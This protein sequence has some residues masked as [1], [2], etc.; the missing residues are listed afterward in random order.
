MHRLLCFF[1]FATDFDPLLVEPPDGSY[2]HT[3]AEC[4]RLVRRLSSFDEPTNRESTASIGTFRVTRVRWGGWL[5]DPRVLAVSAQSKAATPSWGHGRTG[6]FTGGSSRCG[7][8][9]D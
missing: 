6:C 9:A 8:R 7:Q 3:T 4:N 1:S 5:L 2:L